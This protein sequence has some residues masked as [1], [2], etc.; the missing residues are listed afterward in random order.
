MRGARRRIRTLVAAVMAAGLGVGAC[1]NSVTP[2][3]TGGTG[4]PG[5]T[6]TSI[7]V[8]S[9]ANVTGPLSADFAP[10][11]N[12]V[13][14]YFSM[15]NAQGGVSGRKLRLGFQTDD[16]GSS[17]A[18]LTA[19]QKLVEQDHVFAVVGV[20]TPFFGGA[21]YLA[22]Q[23]VPTFG[24]QVS[25]DWS[26]GPSLF[27]TYGSLLDYSAGEAG[28][29]YFAKHVGAK[30]VGIVS[31]SVPQSAAACQ[32]IS[33]AMH[34]YGVTVGYQD[35]AF[36]FGSDPTADVLQM[37]A[38]DVDTLYTCLDVTGNIAFSRAI[39]QNGLTMRQLWLN[40]Y[41]RP[42]LH[43]YASLMSGVYF[44]LQHVPFEAATA[45]PGVYP[46]METYLS[47]MQKYQPSAVYDEVALDG[48]VS[49]ALFVSGLRAVGRH[50][51]QAKVVAAINKETAFTGGGLTT[52]VDWTKSH[53]TAVPPFCSATV[54]VQ[55]DQFVPVVSPLGGV[56]VCF[57]QDSD[58]P[59]PGK[60]GTPGT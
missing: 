11:V 17:S 6:D 15:V 37:K 23:G 56:F 28:F 57:Q 34:T 44:S 36:P 10:I 24:Y 59:V 47:M 53:T 35:L 42:T 8:G 38:H 31:Y 54:M 22:Q 46:G 25:T 30:S 27:G 33:N 48:W 55:D 49:A 1:S 40:G 19:A 52:P 32:A 14:A 20:G 60:P 12:G 16:Q 45:F 4:A 43:Q 26:S 3:S 13:E 9:I 2:P 29:A 21:R 39:Q 51:T 50:V 18:D 5:V 58:L 7:T 41:D